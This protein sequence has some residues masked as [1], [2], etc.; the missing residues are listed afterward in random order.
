MFL[1]IYLGVLVTTY[2]V[3]FEGDFKKEQLEEAGPFIF[4]VSSLMVL[5]GIIG[6][7]LGR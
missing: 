6:S 7:L 4:I 5:L 3:T 2:V 1:M